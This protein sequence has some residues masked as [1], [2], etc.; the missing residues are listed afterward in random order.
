MERA[1]FLCADRDR[2][3]FVQGRIAM[4]PFLWRFLMWGGRFM[5][6]PYETTIEEAEKRSEKRKK[7]FFCWMYQNVQLLAS[8]PYWCKEG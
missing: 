5:K 8:N 4:R 2:K 6:R 7:K 3:I 1:V